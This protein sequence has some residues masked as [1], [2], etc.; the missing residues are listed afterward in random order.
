LIDGFLNAALMDKTVVHFEG[1][2]MRKAGV[3]NLA[4]WDFI[5]GRAPYR[6]HHVAGVATRTGSRAQ[7]A[8]QMAL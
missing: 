7:I 6:M 3:L 2:A 5:R 8:E 1:L 4:Y